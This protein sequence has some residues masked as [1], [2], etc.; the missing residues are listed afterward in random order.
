MPSREK[1]KVIKVGTSRAVC[2]PK[3]FLDYHKVG[4]GDEVT[5][6]Y[7]GGVLMV[8]PRGIEP[9]ALRDEFLKELP[10]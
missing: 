9:E 2:L 7:D 3:P 8:L 10:R 5:L 1:R 6:I 4:E